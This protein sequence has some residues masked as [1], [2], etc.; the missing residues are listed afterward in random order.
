MSCVSSSVALIKLIF[1]LLFPESIYVTEHYMPVFITPLICSKSS[2]PVVH[3][4]C[5]MFITESSFS[6]IEVARNFVLDN[7]PIRSCHNPIICYRVAFVLS[8][9]KQHP[10]TTPVVFNTT[11]LIKVYFLPFFRGDSRRTFFAC[12]FQSSL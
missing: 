7:T 10:I 2:I 6:S 3:Y 8:Y 4:A 1:A 9:N 11:T 12:F 5:W